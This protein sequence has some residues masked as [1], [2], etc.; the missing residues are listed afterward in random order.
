MEGIVAD[1]RTLLLA[2][3]AIDPDSILLY[4]RDF[5]P[6]SLDI[7]IVYMVRDPDAKQYFALRERLNLAFMRAVAARGLSFAFPTQTVHLEQ[8]GENRRE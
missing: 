2:E 4:F 6:S 1:L 8:R 7:W 3:P 5:S